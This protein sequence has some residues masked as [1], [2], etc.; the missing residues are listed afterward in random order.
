MLNLDGCPFV[1]VWVSSAIVV[2]V[3]VGSPHI[4]GCAADPVM[5]TNI[6]LEPSHYD[7]IMHDFVLVHYLINY[8][9][10]TLFMSNDV[11]YPDNLYPFWDLNIVCIAF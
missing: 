6:C 2:V 10:G 9:Q 7:V 4:Y 1:C 8:V 5:A 3:F 11:H